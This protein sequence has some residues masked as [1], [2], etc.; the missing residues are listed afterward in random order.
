MT[1]YSNKKPPSL[2]IYSEEWVWGKENNYMALSLCYFILPAIRVQKYTFASSVCCIIFLDHTDLVTIHIQVTSVK[3][4]K[5]MR[6]TNEDRWAMHYVMIKQ[7]FGKINNVQKQRRFK[8]F[9]ISNYFIL[10]IRQKA[11][12]FEMKSKLSVVQ[13]KYRI[14]NSSN[15]N[16]VSFFLS[17]KQTMHRRKKETS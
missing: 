4:L 3:R 6:A 1:T 16:F 5:R 2:N 8:Y 17:E 7:V 10:V 12:S 13:L 11:N 14:L 9:C 15:S